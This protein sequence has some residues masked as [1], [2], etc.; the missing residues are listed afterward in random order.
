[1]LFSGWTAEAGESERNARVFLKPLLRNGIVLRSL[2][3]SEW[4]GDIY[5]PCFSG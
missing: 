3:Q 1:M 5:S 2:D 4:G